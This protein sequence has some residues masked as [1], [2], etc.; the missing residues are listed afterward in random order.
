M[1]IVPVNIHTYP[2]QG[3]L[4][5]FCGEGVLFKREVQYEASVKFLVGWRGRGSN[6]QLSLGGVWLFSGIINVF[7]N[8]MHNEQ[9]NAY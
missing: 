4:L 3:R 8:F 6:K 2:R 1:I 9:F 5:E 7:S